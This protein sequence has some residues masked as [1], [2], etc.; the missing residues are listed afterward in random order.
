MSKNLKVQVSFA[1]SECT[2]GIF[3][4]P[5]VS[6]VEGRSASPRPDLRARGAKA[7]SVRAAVAAAADVPVSSSTSTP[8]A[9][10]PGVTA[11]DSPSVVKPSG[12]LADLPLGA[13]MKAMVQLAE[14]KA[15]AA[16]TA[17]KV[18]PPPPFSFFYYRL[19]PHCFWTTPKSIV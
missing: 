12:A 9:A 3:V 16:T 19:L 18:D 6:R 15:A 10:G 1:D 7:E 4:S 17:A 2:N 14:A 8:V 11:G 13:G 5:L